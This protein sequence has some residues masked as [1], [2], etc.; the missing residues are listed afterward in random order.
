MKIQ[1]RRWI[2]A[3][4]L[5]IVLPASPLAQA[6][7]DVEARAEPLLK[8][9]SLEEKIDLIGGLD[10]F[11]I[12]DIPRI[13]FPRLKMSDGPEG[14]R[15]YGSSTAVGGVALAASWDAELAQ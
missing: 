9:L 7:A 8:Q 13:H 14:V 4:V 10:A 2:A 1:I 6:Q 11:Y 3:L 5:L 15:N 12:R